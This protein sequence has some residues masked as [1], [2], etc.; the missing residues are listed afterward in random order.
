M[1]SIDVIAL[2]GCSPTTKRWP[3]NSD[4]RYFYYVPPGFASRE[5]RPIIVTLH[6]SMDEKTA[7]DYEKSVD[8][9]R[10]IGE[11]ALN[12]WRSE[13]PARPGSYR[14]IRDI[15]GQETELAVASIRWWYGL[16]CWPGG[17]G[18]YF[19]YEELARAVVVVLKEMGLRGADTTEVL[20]HGLSRG[21]ER[22]WAVTWYIN[23]NEAFR[24]LYVGGDDVSIALTYAHAGGCTYDP[25]KQACYHEITAAGDPDLSGCNYF[26]YAGDADHVEWDTENPDYPGCA[27]EKL[28]DGVTMEVNHDHYYNCRWRIDELVDTWEDLTPLGANVA[29]PRLGRTCLND[30]VGPFD[31]PIDY[32]GLYDIW[33]DQLSETTRTEFL[34]ELET[35]RI[36]PGDPS[37]PCQ[38][39]ASCAHWEHDDEVLDELFETFD[40]C[41]QGDCQVPTDPGGPFTCSR[42]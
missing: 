21:A 37:C 1:S 3:G 6:G 11:Q 29:W 40:R 12:R 30:D 24:S 14:N 25:G 10:E 15:D 42:V 7:Y 4:W 16:D 2:L 23:A 35:T 31:D 41:I 36:Y 20:L 34:E 19:D 13:N 32:E 28:V 8:K 22:S 9:G 18:P 27:G 5:H 38:D 39:A 17:S 33:R 26:P